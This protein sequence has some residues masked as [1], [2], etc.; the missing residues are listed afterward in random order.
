MIAILLLGLVVPASAAWGD[1][2]TEAPK[3]SVLDLDVEWPP[4]TSLK[5]SWKMSDALQSP[6]TTD[7]KIR[8]PWKGGNPAKSIGCKWD[9]TVGGVACSLN[10]TN[11][12]GS[13]SNA[14]SLSKKVGSVCCKLDASSSWPLKP[15]ASITG[16]VDAGGAGEICY[17][18]KSP[19][20]DAS[21]DS[22]TG[23]IKLQK[24]VGDAMCSISTPPTYPLEPTASIKQSFGG[25][26]CTL[27]APIDYTTP[28]KTMKE[29][30]VTASYSKTIDTDIGPICCKVDGSAAAS[31]KYSVTGTASLKKK[32]GAVCANL[33]ANTNGA[34]K[35]TFDTAWTGLAETTPTGLS[36]AA[37]LLSGA[38][39]GSAF[40]LMVLRRLNRRTADWRQEP[41][42]DA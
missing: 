12:F 4:K 5:G 27:K 14:I 31:G 42:L 40:T 15:T 39:A 22:V 2:P 16:A 25:V 10:T 41:L 30:S 13:K 37:G 9:T 19:V 3:K 34:L 17:D 35:C 23:S 11:N 21:L 38:F 7:G 1:A 28:D 24:Q 26:C 18:L 33:E 29:A 8:T 36:I 20:M 6:I 32:I